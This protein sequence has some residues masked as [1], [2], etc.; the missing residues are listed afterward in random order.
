MP[1]DSSGRVVGLWCLGQA[2]AGPA[3]AWFEFGLL[4]IA[5]ASLSFLWL[6]G[7]P[8]HGRE[9]VI[10]LVVSIWAADSGAYAAG[11]S[12]GGPKLAPRISPGK[13]WAGLIGGLISAMLVGGL[14]GLFQD[15]VGTVKLVGLAGLLALISQGGDLLESI[16]KRRFHAKDSGQLI[17][18]HGGIL[19]RVDSPAVGQHRPGGD[20]VV[21]RNGVTDL[22]IA[23]LKPSTAVTPKRISI[24][25]STGSIGGNTIDL[26]ERKSRGLSDRG[27]D[28]P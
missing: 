20:P 12:I 11:R 16:V 7:L 14:L 26:I 24:L 6:R 19:D 28:R 5:V 21:K 1:L 4:Y 22:A 3:L 25:G 27:P 18:G 17:P 2:D 8:G 9:L 23:S 15:S 13:T 10:W